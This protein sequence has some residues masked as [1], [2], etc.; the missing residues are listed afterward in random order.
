[1]SAPVASDT[2]SPFSARYGARRRSEDVVG[3]DAPPDD[4]RLPGHAFGS[5]AEGGAAIVVPG[6]LE[7]VRVG[8]HAFEAQTRPERP[9]RGD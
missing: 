6:H 7:H 3:S 9:F 2:R 1:M 4:V 5:V 8:L